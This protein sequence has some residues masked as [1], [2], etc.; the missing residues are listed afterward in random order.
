[1]DQQ[2]HRAIGPLWREF[3]AAVSNIDRY[4]YAGTGRA[5]A[6]F[7]AA[8]RYLKSRDFTLMLSMCRSGT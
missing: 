5:A 4:W 2:P 7:Q 3:I 8:A 6:S 1:M